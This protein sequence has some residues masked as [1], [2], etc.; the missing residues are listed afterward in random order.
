MR[1]K[2]HTLFGLL[3]SILIFV[4][5][6]EEDEDNLRCTIICPYQLKVDNHILHNGDDLKFEYLTEF[7]NTVEV[8]FARGDTDEI[9]QCEKFKIKRGYGEAHIIVNVG[10]YQGPGYVRISYITKWKDKLFSDSSS[11]T[12]RSVM[13]H[14]ED[15]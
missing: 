9:L 4:G 7:N 12:T 1:A 6:T 14:F 2:V 3:L 10:D 5:C 15:M 11:W 13:V 8:V